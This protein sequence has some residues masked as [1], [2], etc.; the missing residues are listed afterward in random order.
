MTRV[1]LQGNHYSDKG[2]LKN[3]RTNPSLHITFCSVLACTLDAVVFKSLIGGR[4]QVAEPYIYLSMI[5]ES[6]CGA[7]K[8]HHVIH[9]KV[10]T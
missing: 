3:S 10:N 1:L 9:I 8:C 6:K 5:A 7:T 4:H 2:Y